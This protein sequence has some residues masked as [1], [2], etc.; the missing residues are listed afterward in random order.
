MKQSTARRLIELNRVFYDQFAT[1]FSHSRQKMNPGVER[2]FA[3]YLG[4]AKTV[5]DVG[6]GDARVGRWWRELPT[7][8]HEVARR[9]VGVDASV[10]LLEAHRVQDHM[11]LYPVDITAD[12]WADQVQA[13]SGMVT[14]DAVVS[15]AVIHH[16]PIQYQEVVLKGIKSLL[17]EDGTAVIS[18]W[19]FLHVPRLARKL[20]DWSEIDLTPDDVDE[21]DYLMDWQRGGRGIRYVHSHT[22]ERLSALCQSVG[23]EIVATWRSDG[24]TDDMGLYFVLR[25]T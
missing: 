10:G 25:H 15:F 19:Q 24:A 5:L 16:I 6:C 12:D 21:G 3:E 23:F 11:A 8:E 2:A 4:D 9:Y 22:Q 7:K 14:F 20:L 1:A 13:Q 17:A 18:T